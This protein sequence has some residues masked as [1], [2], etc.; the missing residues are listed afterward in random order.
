MGIKKAAGAVGSGVVNAGKAVG[1]GVLVA[2]TAVI[3]KT[4]IPNTHIVV[5]ASCCAGVSAKSHDVAL[6]AMKTLQIEVINRG[7]EPWRG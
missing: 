2:S 6:E 1:K 4:F 3:S 7:K 5:D